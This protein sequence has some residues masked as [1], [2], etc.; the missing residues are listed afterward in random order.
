MPEQPASPAQRAS[1]SRWV[2]LGVL[3]A[4]AACLLLQ[5]AY[6]YLPFMQLIFETRP[7]GWQEWLKAALAGGLLFLLIEA[8]K[9]WQRW[10]TG[11]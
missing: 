2:N 4:I 10:R 9:A 8:E 11:R 6:L 7:L 5:A 3:I 1:H